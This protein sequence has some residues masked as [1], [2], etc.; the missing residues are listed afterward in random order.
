MADK[1]IPKYEDMPYTYDKMNY[2]L[3]ES[4]YWW[5][6][7][8]PWLEECGYM[9]RP[10][11]RPDWVPSW[12]GTKKYVDDFEDGQLSMVRILPSP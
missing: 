10:R 1:Q 9:L 7:H 8:Q 4:E 11:F 3:S 6:K 5:V 12:L 2:G